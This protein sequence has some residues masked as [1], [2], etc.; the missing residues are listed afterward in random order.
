MH[1]LNIIT[2]LVIAQVSCSLGHA[3]AQIACNLGPVD[4]VESDETFTV[5][6]FVQKKTQEFKAALQI[7]E[8][9]VPEMNGTVLD[10]NNSEEV[11]LQTIHE[12]LLATGHQISTSLGSSLR[13]DDASLFFVKGCPWAY[14][15]TGRSCGSRGANSKTCDMCTV[16]T[17]AFVAICLTIPILISIMILASREAPEPLL[18]QKVHPHTGLL[19]V[20]T[21]WWFGNGR[22]MSF[23]E[24]GVSLY[25]AGLLAWL[26][27]GHSFQYNM[28][29][30]LDAP[31]FVRLMASSCKMDKAGCRVPLVESLPGKPP[32]IVM[33]YPASI[34]LGPLPLE[35]GAID[36]S[37]RFLEYLRDLALSGLLITIFALPLTRLASRQ[38]MA[39]SRT[40]GGMV[41]VWCLTVDTS[42]FLFLFAR[43]SEKSSDSN[44][45]GEIQ[46]SQPLTA[47]IVTLS[48]S[49]LGTFVAVRLSVAALISGDVMQWPFSSM[50]MFSY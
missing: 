14:E 36:D 12:S 32:S 11:Q 25:L 38:S 33:P 17:E 21:K 28:P 19:G 30:P 18:L 41:W 37:I 1:I 9:V 20:M 39:V 22:A 43:G 50:P 3:H 29:S 42:R 4:A 10:A 44:G 40:F 23:P 35:E 46:H 7:K 16:R 31:T 2:V 48:L 34:F 8:D 5:H 47:K 13:M 26:L 45:K 15:Q 27:L 24:C 49:S 6:S